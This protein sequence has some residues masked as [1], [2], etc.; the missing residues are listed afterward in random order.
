MAFPYLPGQDPRDPPEVRDHETYLARMEERG[1]EHT[2]PEMANP[3]FGWDP[4]VTPGAKPG[5]GPK[6]LQDIG[7]E[8]PAPAAPIPKAATDD[9]LHTPPPVK[10]LA[11]EPL[12][13]LTAKPA[14][15]PGQAPVDIAP[16]VYPP[17]A[18]DG[19]PG[20]E[21]RAP[22][23]GGGGNYSSM[24]YKGSLGDYGKSQTQ[25]DLEKATAEHA[26]TVGGYDK[27]AAA[28]GAEAEQEKAALFQQHYDEVARQQ[29]KAEAEEANRQKWTESAL[30]AHHR[31]VEKIQKMQVDPDHWWAKKSTGEKITAGIG[32]AFIAF[33][34]GLSASGGGD[35]TIGLK[36]L[37]HEIDND[38]AAQKMNI[39]NAWQGADRKQ[40]IY[41]SAFA[42]FKDERMATASAKASA[43][44]LVRMKLNSIEQS[45]TSKVAKQQAAKIGEQI[46]F[47]ITQ[48]E[49]QVK[50]GGEQNFA[51]MMAR[52]AQ[53]EA[54]AY[55]HD[56]ARREKRD[57]KMFDAKLDWYKPGAGGLPTG[58]SQFDLMPSHAIYPNGDPVLVKGKDG[59][60][61]RVENKHAGEPIVWVD[62]KFQFAGAG[63]PG[64]HKG[65]KEGKDYTVG[66]PGGGT[67][68]ANST[69]GQTALAKEFRE[70]T[71]FGQGLLGV[72]EALRDPVSLANIDNWKAQRAK[73]AAA[74]APY[75]GMG[76]L[77]VGVERIV[78]EILP[79]YAQIKRDPE[80]SM[81]RVNK[82]IAEFNQKRKTAVEIY[83]PGQAF[84]ETAYVGH[85][86]PD[87][88]PVKK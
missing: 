73:A 9:P 48:Y 65:G 63:A 87:I 70:G 71:S 47:S 14:P 78:D 77:D 3:G 50:M 36:A 85:G 81:K 6:A 79:S 31:E 15:Q 44:E 62:G 53:A 4:N 45:T 51:A 83:A 21:R 55:A 20:P 40:N 61:H 12:P 8:A 72:R 10:Y 16:T 58:A 33:G 59:K 86:E 18:G 25:I 29:A 67:V 35:A 80:G 69:E 13:D 22:G 23:G 68:T 39:D 27:A 30:L 19:D 52:R 57:D 82:M 84:P 74:F 1:G 43:W 24:S 26:R 37:Q 32:M 54:A 38:I 76:A 17:E 42:A 7:W 66:M 56:Q 41:Q 11:T 75:M 46:D 60:M 28:Y 34:A 64:P 5:S 2:I 88:Q 49:A